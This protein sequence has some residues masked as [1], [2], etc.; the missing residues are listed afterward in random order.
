M[1][2][3]LKVELT[4]IWLGM[5]TALACW[6]IGGFLMILWVFYSS[7]TVYHL[8]FLIYLLGISG[9]LLG[10]II[11]G[12]KVKK[13]AWLHGLWV[14]VLLGLLGL[15]INLEIAPEFYSWLTLGRQFFVWS[16]WGLVGGYFSR[17]LVRKKIKEAVEEED[18][19]P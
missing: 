16:L 14:G 11:A 13:T 17:F 18:S 3:W 12:S 2:H 8:E 5:V 9:V 19:T 6:L 1:K 4:A 7:A 15:I 10:G